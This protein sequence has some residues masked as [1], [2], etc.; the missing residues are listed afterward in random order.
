M[1]QIKEKLSLILFFIFF[2]FLLICND[3]FAN[4]SDREN[5]LKIQPFCEGN[6][7][8]SPTE[9]NKSKSFP[10]KID[11][12][13]SNS[14]AWYQNLFGLIKYL[15]NPEYKHTIKIPKEFKKYH[16]AKIIV[17]YS[18]NKKCIFEGEGRIHGGRG[19]HVSNDNFL[20]SLR[21][22][23]FNGNINGINN[24]ILFLP[25]SRN[26]DSEVITTL[27]LKKLDIL[28]PFTMNIN[29]N[30]NDTGINKFIFQEKI[31]E[32]FLFKNKKSEGVI[33]AS[34]KSYQIQ[35]NN[36]KYNDVF[37][38]LSFVAANYFTSTKDLQNA[39]NNLNYYMIQ[40][41]IVGKNQNYS[42]KIFKNTDLLSSIDFANKNFERLSYINFLKFEALML[43]AGANHGLSLHDIKYY[44]DNFYN[45]LEPIYY[46]GHSKILDDYN[47]LDDETFNNKVF[48]SHKKGAKLLV[49]SLKKINLDK[50][51][52]DLSNRNV[53]L[54]RE[55]IEKTINLLLLNLAS[56]INSETLN[57]DLVNFNALN[58]NFFEDE[59]I[60]NKKVFF[61]FG[62]KN[63]IVKICNVKLIDCETRLIN[64]R[65]YY[66]IFTRQI[67]LISNKNIFYLAG[68]LDSYKTRDIPSE[69]GIESYKKIQ[70]DTNSNIF[71]LYP[72][73]NININKKDNLIDL[74]VLESKERI[75][76]ISNKFNDWSI[77]Y[78][79]INPLR[80]NFKKSLVKDSF[81]SGCIN[82]LDSKIS[83]IKLKIDTA[84][85]PDALHFFRSKGDI[86]D[87]AVKD[88]SYDALDADFSYLTI[89]KV[90]IDSANQECI[91][92]KSGEYFLNS[93]FLK[94]CGD[95]GLS[96]GELAQA[97]VVN[98]I[99][100]DSRMA[101]V[102]KDTSEIVIDEL[103]SKN[104][105]S[106]CLG[107][108]KG[109]QNFTGSSIT[110]NYPVNNCSENKFVTQ[111]GSFINLKK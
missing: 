28:S 103:I 27:I 32:N 108:Y 58:F 81:P 12:Q 96:A 45:K 51:K 21:I 13:F 34:N 53:N 23:M 11:I 48:A 75:I 86:R 66:D 25:E 110:V 62:G 10:K 65:D 78:S 19:D 98:A 59:K 56:I 38:R 87:I 9:L 79:N 80:K 24:F 46:D 68:S 109:K 43:A 60:S 1:F 74:K 37:D 36:I 67:S 105:S 18:N 26:G 88:S 42:K 6:I 5:I 73:T 54:S 64:N 40:N 33:L 91:G 104:I 100:E 41:Y 107:A 106:F 35:D 31:D 15:E 84:D 16:S 20:S 22:R 90:K 69:H 70:L 2:S 30:I 83:N 102:S 95:K 14:N 49:E 82:F 61:A 50:F 76:I 92:L 77:N 97:S 94:N 72:S 7:Y 3:A 101:V 44:F 111:K 29:V 57:T 99:I 89:D 17:E 85:C 39:V 47:L 52:K 8:F 55:N 4:N 71:Y 93:I 63:N